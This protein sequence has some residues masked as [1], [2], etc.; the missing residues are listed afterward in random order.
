MRIINSNNP[1][2][3]FADFVL[4]CDY[5]GREID[6]ED[7]NLE[8]YDQGEAFCL[9]KY[10][11]DAFR[12]QNKAGRLYWVGLEGASITVKEAGQTHKINL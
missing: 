1:A 6:D 4:V 8:F 7:A 2:H 10:C 5:C 11:S 9:H 3:G 12:K